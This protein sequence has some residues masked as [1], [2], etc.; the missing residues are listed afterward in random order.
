ML[1]KKN[2]II[3]G[4]CRDV[5]KDIPDDS[6]DLVLTDPPY[7][8]TANKWDIP[9]D[10]TIFPLPMVCFASQPFSSA[11]IMSMP[12]KFKHEWI[13]VKNRGSNFA[14]T[15]RE[16]MK[17]HEHVLFFADTSWTYNK[18][19]QE[20]AEGGKARAQYNVK[21]ETESKNY[22]QFKPI[23]ENK[24]TD[25]RVPSSVQKFNCETGLHPTQKPV[26]LIKYLI[27]TYSKEGQT[28][29]DPFAGSFTTA[30]ACLDLNRNYIC[31]ERG[32]EYFDIGKKRIAEH[33][34]QM[35]LF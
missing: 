22:N 17:E 2:Q 3:L 24:L 15:V 27:K 28:I 13:W 18:Q 31:I 8:I 29:L 9:V 1:N 23:E 20:R 21:F 32:K 26:E 12:D 30:I 10:M 14:N 16:P 11:L 4:D 33:E 19:M 7:G 25:K 34:A 5:M 6:I 35:T